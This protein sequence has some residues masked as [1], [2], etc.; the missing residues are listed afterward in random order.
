MT[1]PNKTFSWLS[2]LILTGLGILAS[3]QQVLTRTTEVAR[4]LNPVLSRYEVLRF[5]PDEI[6]R[7]IR[8]KG[9]L[10]FRFDGTE[11]HFNIKPHYMRSPGYR[12][13]ETGAGG[14]RRTLPPQ[15]VHTF[16]GTL[17]GQEETRGRF[18][19]TGHGV[20]GV[21]FV[22]QGWIYLE[23]LRNYLQS[24][25]AGEL[26]VY[27][28]A[29]IKPGEPLKCGVSLPERLRR[30]VARVEARTQSENF[31]SPTKY[32]V[33]VATEADYEYVQ[34]FGGSVEANREIEGV[35][36]VVD[37]V[38]QSELLLRL[39]I[40]FQHAW[41]AKGESYPY[42]ATTA[43]ELEEQF[44][45]YWNTHYATEKNYDLAHLWTGIP[46]LGG[47]A[48]GIGTVCRLRSQS[49]ALSGY[50]RASSNMS[51]NYLTPAHEIG[52]LLGA[53]H[54]D[55]QTTCHGTIMPSSAYWLA[56]PGLTFCGVS[57]QAIA[58]YIENN[59]SCLATQTITLQPPS[60][61]T[62]TVASSS[63]INLAWKDNSTD[64]SGFIVQRRRNGSGEWV[65]IAS[66]A[67]DTIT[68]SNDRLFSKST[69]IYRV[70]AF[71]DSE[72]SAYSNDAEATTP[73]GTPVVIE[74]TID[75][76]A[77]IGSSGHSG[78]GGPA[79]S[80]MLNHPEGV[81]VDSSGNLYIAD[82]W[83]H[84]I[85]KVDTSGTI[86]TFAGTGTSGCCNDGGPAK[87]AR[88]T[89]P[90]DVAVDGS[91]NLYIADGFNGRL[92]RV[93]SQEIITTV[94]AGLSW[95]KGIALDSSGNIYIA[96]SSDH[97]IRR[98][99][100]GGTITTVA[101]T[102]QGGFSGDGGLATSALLNRPEDVAVDSSG[103][104][105]IADSLN[106]RI[107]RVDTSGIIT[108]FA[109][110]GFAYE[111]D[112]SGPATEA[113]LPLPSGVAVDGS[114]NI[115]IADPSSQRIKQVDTSGTLV[116]IAGSGEA[117]SSGD[118]GPA[119]EAQLNHP[120]GV[121]VDTAGRVYVAERL[122]HRIRVLSTGSSPSP[123]P[124]PPPPKPPKPPPPKPP[125]PPPPKPPTPPP[126]KPPP[127]PPPT[128]GGGG[129]FGAPA[130]AAPSAPRE[131]TAVGG[132]GEVVLSWDAPPSDGGAPITDYQYRIDESGDWIAIGSTDTTH[133]VSGMLNGATYVF[134]VRA[135]NRI[136]P[137]RASSLVEV[138]LE[139]LT[140]DFTHFANGGAIISELVL[141]NLKD[142]PV[143]PAMYFSDTEGNLIDPE[144][145]VDI[146]KDLEVTED[147]GLRVLTPMELLEVLTITTHG[148][149]DL[150][151]GSVR[152][153]SGNPLGGLLRWS[154]P[155]SGVAAVEASLPVRDITFPAR[156][157]QGGI[158]TSAALHN[159]GEAALEV[160]CR[161]MSGGAVLE[162]A[163][164]P[165]EGNGQ[166]SWT[167]DEAFPASDTSDFLG[168]V[169]CT[170][171]RKFT[172]IAVEM[173]A[174]N[175]IFTTLP[176]LQVSWNLRGE[177][178]LDMAHLAN[179]E[180][181]ST[182]LVLVNLRTQPSRPTLSPWQPAIPPIHPRIYFYGP[183]GEML[184]PESVV[185]ITG[186][187]EVAEDGGLRVGTEIAPLEVLTITTHGRG[188]L[189]TGSVQVVSEGPL[190][191]MLRFK[192]PGIGE[193]VVG[194]SL[195]LSDVVFPVRRQQGGLDTGIAIHNLDS[196]PE[197]VRCD[198]MQEGV[199]RDSVTIP[200]EANG[201][202]SW[203]LDEAFPAT[204]TSDFLGTVRCVAVGEGVF[205][206]LALE[207][208][209]TT[210]T[211]TTLP[212]VPVEESLP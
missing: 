185:D 201:Q 172:A 142:R 177:T 152:V 209:P 82:R 1:N 146:T 100:T 97:R 180:N 101:G 48:R 87:L 56:A 24:A 160:S 208:D 9:K 30:G 129:G 116:I 42:T 34:E 187:L 186:D 105:Y 57:R 18:N 71:N 67:A 102:G 50:D 22:P 205:T 199:L 78:D 194:A 154:V 165:L 83:N 38:Y 32:V 144:S 137:S 80:A 182:D 184:A 17:V 150:V 112:G 39:Q 21:I 20:E 27:N 81:A 159:P 31:D 62:A 202:A 124:T 36:N 115:Y 43:G 93:N 138:T 77:G 136:G 143:R 11:F 104:V 2:V 174:G 70:Q 179:G 107:R 119:L 147:G 96:E 73:A 156:R 5:E 166:T 139:L 74:R 212:L 181:W 111:S 51:S 61:L 94:A 122:G 163:A 206:A 171:P 108:T 8:S 16:K 29:D 12:A 195:P 197:L 69:Y 193:A 99:D 164:I 23:P 76:I 169:H 110:I 167:I 151:T 106:Y 15:P 10:R 175:G 109:G 85:R 58:K 134:E 6:E 13:M 92:R 210:G 7:R 198:L 173:D 59:N 98:V 131:L 178:A 103:N 84:R 45:L 157:R 148:W 89:W 196:S 211:F 41:A 155:G 54:P 90:E 170:A 26:V 190:G 120:E 121:A 44:V 132:D 52:H 149:G 49:Y 176:I 68:F 191:G 55:D 158:Q 117:G 204:D 46:T 53:L 40:E 192:H 65:Q 153:A 95:F 162:A 203:P 168:T 19:L 189:T 141:V 123:P 33:D 126:P 79:T 125:T 3:P 200:L 47:L 14:L 91:G 64:E 130:P 207:I 113:V 35:L 188:D 133:T 128:G 135:V 63:S 28:H 75:T 4:A 118:G 37:G 25:Q 88:M 60:G 86:T 140:L 72:S 127:T 161:L 145:V 183:E 66:I 114:G